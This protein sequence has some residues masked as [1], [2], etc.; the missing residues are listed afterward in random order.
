M[1][2]YSVVLRQ[3][4]FRVMT[5]AAQK[6]ACLPISDNC[7]AVV[8]GIAF[9]QRP[10][11]TLLGMDEKGGCQAS[12]RNF[13]QSVA[14]RG[15]TAETRSTTFHCISCT[16]VTQKICIIVHAIFPIRINEPRAAVHLAEN[17]RRSVRS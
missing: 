1:I 5:Q 3:F 9:C 17:D 7:T 10:I 14:E 13:E 16:E 4:V 2:D 8:I 12:C 6:G 11:P 15:L